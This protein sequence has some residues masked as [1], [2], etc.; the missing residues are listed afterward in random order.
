MDADPGY[1]RSWINGRVKELVGG[2]TGTKL[3]HSKTLTT[4]TTG[5]KQ[6]VKTKNGFMME[7]IGRERIKGPKTFQA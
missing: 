2:T 3:K 6:Q 5:G 7:K 1:F 4:H